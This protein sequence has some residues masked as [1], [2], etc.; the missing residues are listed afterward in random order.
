[1][2]Q[3]S[4]ISCKSIVGYYMMN[5][6]KPLYLDPDFR[7]NPPSDGEYCVR[8]QKPLTGKVVEVTVNWDNL[9]VVLE[10][11]EK[12]GINCWKKISKETL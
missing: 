5:L 3:E 7:K 10:G 1:M 12:M 6:M 8:C 11:S 9:T 4:S 2:I